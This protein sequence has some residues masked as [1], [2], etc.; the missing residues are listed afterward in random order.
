MEEI[1]NKIGVPKQIYSDQEGSFNS[2]EFIRLINKH[3]I[4]HIMVLGKAH[5]VE[6][7]N[8]TLKEKITERLEVLGGDPDAWTEY[9]DE[10]LNKYNAT[11][12]STIKMS[13]HEARQS[14]NEEMVR[15]NIWNKAKT[16]RKYPTL[17][18][19]DEVRVQ[20]RKDN[21][22]KG[23]HPKY[24]DSV[25]KVTYKKGNEY[26]VNNNRHKVYQRFELLKV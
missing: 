4:K 21:K 12:Q 13:P 26:L 20:L 16:D 24:S 18:V 3:H 10:V 15:F 9:L 25:F 5:T 8:R 11:E 22:T 23:Y 6:R 17:S 7:F 2:P 1:L 14:K 19:G